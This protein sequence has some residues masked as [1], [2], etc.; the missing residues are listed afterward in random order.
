[1]PEWLYR[2][3]FLYPSSGV[4]ILLWSILLSLHHQLLATIRSMPYWTASDGNRMPNT[5]H[6]PTHKARSCIESYI[7]SLPFCT[8]VLAA[9]P[10]LA[11]PFFYPKY[12]TEKIHG[13]EH[14]APLL[15]PNKSLRTGSAV[16]L[17]RNKV[18]P[19]PINSD[20]EIKLNNNQTLYT[21]TY[22]SSEESDQAQH[23]R[24]TQIYKEIWKTTSKTT[25]EEVKKM[26]HKGITPHRKENINGNRNFTLSQPLNQIPS[27]CLLEYGLKAHKTGTMGSTCTWAQG[28]I[29]NRT[30][31]VPTVF[32]HRCYVWV[33]PIVAS[34]KRLISPAKRFMLSS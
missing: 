27:L 7:C 20:S 2:S 32:L 13:K 19:Y 30:L 25:V 31:Y 33:D 18:H 10:L 16:W 12:M 11:T 6:H 23:C 1:M 8:S 4:S 29:N 26:Q 9:A 28:I 5:A 14:Y 21:A 17:G 3:V 22:R 15:K 24:S 34:S